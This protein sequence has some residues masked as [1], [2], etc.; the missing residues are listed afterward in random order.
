MSEPPVNST[1]SD[2]VQALGA[3]IVYEL[4]SWMPVEM[5]SAIGGWLG[6]TIGPR[7]GKSR[8]VRRN[9]Q[10]AFP[11]W[12]EPQLNR[13]ICAFWDNFGR[14]MFEFPHL[15]NLRFDGPRPH[16]ETVGLHHLEA[17]RD[18]GKAG[19]VFSAHF[20]NWEVLPQS[21]VLIGLPIHLLYR[22]PN[23]PMMES[24]FA[25][26]YR[27]TGELVPKGLRGMRRAVQLMR[28]GGHL[29]VLVDQKMNQGIAVPFFGRD[30]MTAP[31]IAHLAMRFDCP[32][33]P[34]RVERLG[35]CR[36]RISFSPPL[37]LPDTG[38]TRA[39]AVAV[40]TTVNAMLEEWIRERP[41]QWLW[42]HRRWPDS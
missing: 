24:L 22:A 39:D 20:A 35:G 23:N 28:A 32:L 25:E 26:R 31:A 42:V 8:I 12:N 37:V 17:L 7:L 3:R 10:A 15:R 33:I 19:I 27:G 21:A 6:R 2:R 4:V 36:L 40:M 9:L 13:T 34:A 41:E 16:V 11:T 5:A 30:A 14:T 1:V 18:D 38:D 29:G